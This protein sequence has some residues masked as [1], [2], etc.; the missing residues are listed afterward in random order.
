M[1]DKVLYWFTITTLLMALGSIV[2]FFFFQLYPFEVV[3][4]REFKTL[5]N[6]AKRNEPI[7]VAILFDKYLSFNAN[8][9]WSLVC[10]DGFTLGF[11]RE[12]VYRDVGAKHIY[13]YLMVPEFAPLDECRVEIVLDYRITPMRT[14]KYIWQ[15]NN[16]RVVE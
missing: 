3:K 16:F 5:Q 12:S 6:E 14:I 11:P 9:Q 7:K 15:S 1:K 10:H 8:T 13:T 4:L 2:F